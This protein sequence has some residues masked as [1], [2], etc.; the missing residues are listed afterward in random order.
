MPKEGITR[1]EASCVEDGR[2]RHHAVEGNKA[3]GRPVSVAP[4]DL[5]GDRLGRPPQYEVT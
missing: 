3:V 5:R 2:E 1:E 4:V